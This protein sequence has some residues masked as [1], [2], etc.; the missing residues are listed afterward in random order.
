[1][2]CAGELEQHQAR[3]WICKNSA[4]QRWKLAT[5]KC[6]N[7]EHDAR[8]TSTAAAAIS[9]VAPINSLAAAGPSD[10]RL[11][12]RFAPIQRK[13][14]DGRAAHQRRRPLTEGWDRR[15]HCSAHPGA[16]AP[17]RRS[18]PSSQPRFPEP[19]E[20]RFHEKNWSAEVT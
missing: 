8:T 2:H 9:T 16:R 15:F 20:V 10:R 11:R 4:K 7:S 19:W 6:K 1:L 13:T 3:D 18:R 12:W 17:P 14:T 5:E